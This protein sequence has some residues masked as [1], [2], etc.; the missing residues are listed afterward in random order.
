MHSPG[1][2]LLQSLHVL[3]E[4][5]ANAIRFDVELHFILEVPNLCGEVVEAIMDSLSVRDARCDFLSIDTL[6][7][8]TMTCGD[9][10]YLPKLPDLV[11]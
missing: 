6:Y 11:H 1:D 4:R 5:C 7:G 3:K 10:T 2:F 8:C 9:G